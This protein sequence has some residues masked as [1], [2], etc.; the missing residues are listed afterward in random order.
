M[1]NCPKQ[2]SFIKQGQTVHK[3]VI[4]T[5]TDTMY[6]AHTYIYIYI[7]GDEEDWYILLLCVQ[8]V[9]THFIK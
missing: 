9:V 4:D 2:P 1:K 3:T 8:E 5:D 7:F 6:S